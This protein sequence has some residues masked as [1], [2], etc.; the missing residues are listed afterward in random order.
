MSHLYGG[1]ETGGT[2]V[3]CALGT[4][5]D[6][7]V[8]QETFATGE[9]GPTLERIAAFFQRGPRPVAIGVGSFGPVDLDPG[10]PTWGHV[11]STPKPGWA[12]T[13]VAPALRDRL[14]VPVHFDTDV[15]T[16]A[17]G[18]HRWGAAAGVDSV[19]Y[20]T[21]GT[22]IGAGLLID[23]RPVH[24]L[25]HPEVGH[26]PIP[27]DRA[28]DPFPGS[29]ASHGD[30]WEGLAAGGAIAARWDADPRALPDG[31]PA[32]ALEAEYVALGIF[33][34]VL[35]ASPQR[36]VVGGG[37]MERP[38]LLAAVGARLVA[39]NAGY[40]ETPMIGDEVGRYVVAPALGDRAGV[41]GAIALAQAAHP[42]TEG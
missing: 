24:G 36:I 42:P 31:H 4:G 1:V 3:V 9:P 14:G 12:H 6:D 23:G 35:V 32:W 28:R 26:L 40:L 37:V 15:T 30:C 25:I 17:L 11:T 7:I 38:G 33:A 18:E 41:L 21:I 29:C 2:W 19:C 5:P 10:S 8:A 27:H 20:L 34:I 13:P 22:G 16:A 39:L